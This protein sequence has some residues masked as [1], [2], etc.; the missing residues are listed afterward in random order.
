MQLLTARRLFKSGDCVAD[1]GTRV[2]WYTRFLSDLVGV[3]G[4]VC[5]G[6]PNVDNF[7]VL[8]YIK[9]KP[10]VDDVDPLNVGVS[11]TYG[12]ARIVAPLDGDTGGP[13][14]YRTQV[15]ILDS[16]EAPGDPFSIPGL[17]G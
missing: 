14:S 17:P 7:E 1:L 4:L 8:S 2:G 13:D 12:K 5:S 10:W 3:H 11:D 16:G 6:E 15:V 9:K